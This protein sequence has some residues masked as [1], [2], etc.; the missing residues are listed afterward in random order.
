MK[1][2]IG[3]IVL[4]TSISVFGPAPHAD[5]CRPIIGAANNPCAGWP[6]WGHN[7]HKRHK[8]HKHHGQFVIRMY[9]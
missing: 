1:K 5:A 2:I 4:V 6:Y 8:H 7:Y 9:R 3:L